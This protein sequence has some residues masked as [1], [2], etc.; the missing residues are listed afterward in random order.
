MSTDIDTQLKILES[1]IAEIMPKGGLRAKLEKS[2]ATGRPLN[3]KLGVDPTAPDLH[4]GHAVP[5]RKLRQFQELGHQ[6]ILIIG[7]FTARV[8][9]P[10]GR[11][12]TRPHLTAEQVKENATTYTDQAFKIL[13]KD[14]TKLV[15]NSQW[16]ASLTMDQ[17]LGLIARFTVAGLLVRDDFQKRYKQEQPIGLH[18]FLYPVM[19]AYDSVVLE[20]DIEVGGSDQRFNLL[21]GRELQEKLGNEPQVCV[22]LPLLEG[23]DG[24]RKMSKSYGN[25]IGLTASPV[26]M[27]YA[28]MKVS[29]ALLI[30]YFRLTTFLEEKEILDI[31][32]GLESGELHPRDVHLRLAREIVTIYHDAEQAN[33][34]EEAY[35]EGAKAHSF[36]VSG[37]VNAISSV[38]LSALIA[39]MI[40]ATS[41][42]D[43]KIWLPELV[44][45][46][47]AAS[48]NGGA[49]RL[50]A[51]GGV[52]L[53]GVKLDDP[54]ADIEIS[55]GDILQIGKRP[56]VR[57]VLSPDDNG[58]D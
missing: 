10:S 57:I 46:E 6:V 4:L 18:E 47:G 8:G 37:T 43:G 36:P 50:V 51:Q 27:L 42:K 16:L 1:G 55:E 9:D 19:Q 25:H 29:D 11:S 33:E 39:A 30:K 26:D 2:A 7:D 21:A 5:L 3:V 56:R 22:M 32:H 23:T 31:E 44:K 52:R 49:R 48:S 20:A 14:K 12:K 41:L 17:V 28:I 45:L 38:S 34:A 15:F 13:D 40:P 24:V 54:N 35:I 58:P 53:N